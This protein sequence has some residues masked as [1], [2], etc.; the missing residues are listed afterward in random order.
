MSRKSGMGL[1]SLLLAGAAAFAYYK[2]SKMS[3]QQKNDLVNGL[4]E[5]G[6]K[7]YDE[8]VPAGLK[9]MINKKANAKDGFT[10]A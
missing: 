7:F 10:H 3:D 5:K 4:K 1:G 8:K 9:D 2:Y 6:K